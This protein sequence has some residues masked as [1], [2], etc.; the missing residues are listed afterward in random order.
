[1]SDNGNDARLPRP[2]P[3]VGRRDELERLFRIFGGGT[4]G[5]ELRV[6][7]GEG[8]VGKSRL[9][10]TLAEQAARRHWRV[11][12]GRAYPVE[13]GV[14]YAVMADAFVPLLQS[15]EPAT[16]TVLS[17]GRENDL[18]RLFPAL[19]GEAAPEAGGLDPDE[20]RTRLFWSFGSLLQRFGDREPVL[21]VLED[22]HWADPSSLSLLHFLVR[23]L[24]SEGVRIVA[25]ST[26]EDRSRNPRLLEM[27]RSLASLD[28]LERLDLRPFNLAE[29]QELLESVFKVSGP[30]VS[31]F[32]ERLFGWT[33]GNAYFV[34]QTLRSLV[35]SGELHHRDGTWLGWEA[36][37]LVLPS[38]IRD[39]VAARFRE[40]S[41]EALDA[42]HVM[43]ALGRP[44]RID[45]LREVMEVDPGRMASVVDELLGSGAVEEVAR[46][47]GVMLQFLH[48]LTR[49][50]LYRQ[51]TV[52][53]QLHLHGRIVSA[54]ETVYGDAAV[55]HA[56]ELAFHLSRIPGVADPRTA[57]YLELAGRG[58]LERH[59]DEEAADYLAAAL[60]AAQ[61][62]VA[63]QD[64]PGA[65]P[66]I[67]RSLARALTRMGRYDEARDH[68]ERLLTLAEAQENAAEQAGALRHL[69]L[70]SMWQ[71]RH[72]DG[73]ENLAAARRV[74]PDDAPALGARIELASG[75][76]LQQLGRAPESRDRIVAALE[77][78]R[79]VGDPALLAWVH[80]A[81]ALI[82]TF[83]GNTQYARE[84]AKQA[85]EL[86][87]TTDDVR[88]V[89][90]G[91]W[92][93]AS[94]EG[95]T[96]GPGP[97]EPWLA[98]A[99]S[100]AKR[101]GSPVLALHVDELE[102]E[103][104]YHTG[105]WDAAL[106]LG[107]RAI[108][109]ARSLNQRAL[110]VRLLVWT[111]SVYVG[112]G[113]LDRAEELVEEATKV[114]GIQGAS[115]PH[116]ADVHAAV[117]ALIG[118]TALR[119][120]QGRLTEAV[121][122]GHAGLAV[123]EA[124]G[125]VIWALR[126]LPLVGEAYVRLDDV[127]RASQVMER[128]REEG[129]KMDHRMSLVYAEAAHAL[130]TRHSGDLEE[131]TRLL[132]EAAD[133][134]TNIGIPYEAARIRRQH[135]GRLAELGRT[136]E[137]DAELREVHDVFLELGAE[138]E[139]QRTRGMFLEI[140]ETPPPVHTGS[141]R[142]GAVL[143]AREWQIAELVAQRKSNKEIA[144]ILGIAQRT[145]TTHC[146][147]IYKKLDLDGSPTR[148]RV[149]LGDLV[150]EGRLLAAS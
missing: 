37:D 114:A 112:R 78:A 71:G 39:A 74:V 93:L 29:I 131:A 115:A 141:R 48:P 85:V 129:R 9:A 62:P 86:G 105:D 109:L 82:N 116:S 2:L 59:A 119:T 33:R 55:D 146:T 31:E 28:L 76:A 147:N 127:E 1:M 97:M 65:P 18:R 3:L 150:R 54:L 73:L 113:D 67:R 66:R 128:F 70:I 34:E 32:A 24:E 110:L 52:T 88:V 101:L 77:L 75:I 118:Q 30:T 72:A 98:A 11:V 56:D 80:R 149:I 17:R 142:S 124:S 36:Q 123:A 81:L 6:L 117:P 38:T 99:R 69:G 133:A 61:A 134:M 23:H 25:T 132:A 44:A 10:H 108:N 22:L 125:Y 102:L 20:L 41:E 51:L 60:E 106:R 138:P 13:R 95:L 12:R 137:A 144:G 45:V 91:E 104:L 83:S 140:G 92:V 7:V 50:S 63:T 135:A 148:K 87:S 145:V 84:H 90:W 42:A 43:A 35:E 111:S 121:D 15:L 58:A 126:L 8:G 27:E 5:V 26:A 68:W 40:V 53:R 47:G 143:S 103:Y 16:M 4:S 21:V 19:G 46:D 14:P 57:R 89:F 49:E 100:S 96:Q 120:A 122:S 94:L 139:L 130:V 107:N 64:D 79:R 136:A